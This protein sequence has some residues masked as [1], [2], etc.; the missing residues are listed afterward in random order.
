MSR[1]RGWPWSLSRRSWPQGVRVTTTRARRPRAHRQPQRR[2]HRTPRRHRRLRQPRRTIHSPRPSGP[3]SRDPSRWPCSM[4]PS[5]RSS[6][7]SATTGVPPL[8]GPWTSSGR[9]CSVTCRP[10]VTPCVARP[11]RAPSS[12]WSRSTRHRPRPRS[13]PSRPCPPAGTGTCRRATEPRSP[14]TSCCRARPTVARIRR[15]SSTPATSRVT[16]TASASASCSPRSAM[17]TSASTCVA[18]GAAVAR[19][20]TSS[21]PN[22]STATT[23]S[24]PSPP[25][26]GCSDTGSGWSASPIPASASSSWH[27]H[28]RRA[29]PR[30][31][32]CR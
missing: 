21:L 4:R 27:R 10:A 24:R 5:A 6:S 28:S 15:S 3:S 7:S 13:T 32:R 22:C 31:R 8:P 11:R 30:S 16:R 23:S 20:S 26:R 9:C 17:P 12:R 19:S 29:S 25:N 14:S 1:R 2:P 18:A